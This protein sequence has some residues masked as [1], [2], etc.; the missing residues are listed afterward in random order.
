MHHWWEKKTY[1]VNKIY[2]GCQFLEPQV[3]RTVEAE[4][5]ATGR[6][7]ANSQNTHFYLK[8]SDLLVVT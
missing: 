7:G 2:I 1:T 4:H 6:A 5:Y 3:K 8:M